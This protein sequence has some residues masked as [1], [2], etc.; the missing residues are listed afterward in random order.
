MGTKLGHATAVLTL[1]P[2]VTGMTLVNQRFV[3]ELQRRGTLTVIN[4]SE[5]GAGRRRSWKFVRSLRHLRASVR[6]L[7]GAAG[8]GSLYLAINSGP[9]VTL[10]IVL[11]SAARIRRRPVYLHHHSFRFINSPSKLLR[12][13]Y[14]V[15][16]DGITDIV[17]CQKMAAG[18]RLAYGRSQFRLVPNSVDSGQLTI[19]SPRESGPIRLGHLS[20]L[21]LE[22]GVGRVIKA[23][24]HAKE[25]G[26]PVE[27]HLAGRFATD[28][29]RS[30]VV[31]ALSAWPGEVVHHGFIAGDEKRNFYAG[32]NFFLYPTDYI[33][34]AQ[35]LVL[36]EALSAGVPVITSDRGC[37]GDL[38]EEACEDAITLTGLE[39]FS[40]RVVEVVQAMIADQS[41]ES[42]RQQ[43][44]ATAVDF[45]NR[46]SNALDVVVDEILGRRSNAG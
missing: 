46:A 23:F 42:R 14:R 15:G 2:P 31:R 4:L 41:H 26:L 22:K 1:P 40:E 16:G 35:P 3:A 18:L 37:I 45:A 11:V 24:E 29:A 27:L 36:L 21:S 12:C 44:S 25:C 5:G 17:L 30:V 9:A 19:A 39:T 7:F 34:E 20:N 28:D 38:A 6:V 8:S 32:L 10:D 43:A 33:V 13:L